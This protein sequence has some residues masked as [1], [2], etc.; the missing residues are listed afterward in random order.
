MF[1][2]IAKHSSNDAYNDGHRPPLSPD[3][4]GPMHLMMGSAQGLMVLAGVD[5]QL[6]DRKEA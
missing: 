1:E 2:Y 3:R 5:A 6:M 4:Q